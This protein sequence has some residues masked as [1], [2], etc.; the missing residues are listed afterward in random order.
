MRSLLTAA[1][2]CVAIGLLAGCGSGGD[3]DVQQAA[4]EPLPID[5]TYVLPDAVFD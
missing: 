3:H 2:L 5:T 1:V 4:H